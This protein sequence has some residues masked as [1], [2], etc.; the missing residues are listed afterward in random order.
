MRECGR[1]CVNVPYN[2]SIVGCRGEDTMFTE[3]L[4]YW[5]WVVCSNFPNYD[6]VLCELDSQLLSFGDLASGSAFLVQL[7]I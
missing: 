1:D 5:Q 2:G 4:C 3:N 6:D 7:Y